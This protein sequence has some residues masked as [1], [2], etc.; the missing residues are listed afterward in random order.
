MVIQTAF[1]IRY[2]LC[3]SDSTLPGV[4]WILSFV[5]TLLVA[6]QTNNV[7]A[8]PGVK[9]V[10]SWW[11][12]FAPLFAFEALMF[13]SLM[14]VLCNEF[15]GI[16]RLTRWQ[17]GASVLYT[18]SLF[19]GVIGEIMM[20]KQIDYRW[21]TL[22]F[23]SAFVFSSLVCASIALYIVGKYH[24]ESLM[25]SKGGAVPVPLT[26]TE[27]GW[28]TN[29]AIVEQ[30]ILLGDIYLTNEGLEQ[31]NRKKRCNSD[32][33]SSQWMMSLGKRGSVL[34]RLRT[35][36]SKPSK[37]LGSSTGAN[38]GKDDPESR[39]YNMM[40]RRTSGSYSDIKV[41]IDD[42]SE[43][44]EVKSSQKKKSKKQRSNP[45]ASGNP[46]ASGSS[47]S[48]NSNFGTARRY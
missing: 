24:V 15:Q 25:A 26:K 40:R 30:W 21:G 27:N 28:I 36:W 38:N 43:V 12:V 35:W 42:E 8:H 45:L 7:W 48:S 22:T 17:L 47:S 1:F 31:R 19:A 2:L 34:D 44:E 20:L 5:F 4:C 32:V 11:V 9:Y 10:L 3:R 18:L 41:E 46:I 37:S 16:Y 6:Y 39:L 14:V 23:A 33:E 13:G 29:H